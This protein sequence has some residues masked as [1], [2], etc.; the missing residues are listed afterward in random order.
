MGVVCH[1]LK[2]G[3]KDK[4]YEILKSEKK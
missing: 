1:V 3:A 2:Q 4:F